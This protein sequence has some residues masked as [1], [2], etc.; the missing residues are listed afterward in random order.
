M[1]EG[2]NFAAGEVGFFVMHEMTGVWHRRHFGIAEILAQSIYPIALEDG[3]ALAP[4]DA[5]RQIDR[6]A[7]RLGRLAAHC[8][9]P[10]LVGADVPVEAA[11]E[12][13]R[14]EEVVDPG[15]DILVEG[16][17]IMRPMREEMAEIEAAGLARAADER[18]GPGLLVERLVPDLDEMLGR[19]PACADAGIWTVEEEQAA[20]TFAMLPREA[21]CNVRPDIMRDDAG[22]GDAERVH[23]RQNICGMDIRRRLCRKLQR[24]LLAVAEAAQVW[25]DHVEVARQIGNAFAPDQP[26]FRPA[27]Q[28][29]QRRTS[30]FAHIVDADA[31]R[32]HEARCE[33]RHGSEP[34]SPTIA[35]IAGAAKR[36]PSGIAPKP[37]GDCR[38]GLGGLAMTALRRLQRLI[39][40][41]DEVGGFLEAD[42]QPHQ[43]IIDAK[44][45]PLF[46]PQP[47]MRGGGGMRDKALAVAQVVR[48]LD[49]L[50]RVLEA[51]GTGLAAGHRN[52][53]QR[54]R[55]AHLPPSEL[56][57]RM[58]LQARIEHAH[59]LAVTLDESGDFGRR[60]A[61]P[62][63]P[64]IK[65]LDALEQKPGIER[66]E[67]RPGMAQERHQ[68]LAHEGV[69][70]EHGAA[71]AAP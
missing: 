30:P 39:E 6:R 67:R 15:L 5:R 9:E 44:R 54:A 53:H 26:E 48:D 35:V 24:R 40:I 19:R 16:M 66:A 63:D 13:A 3:I 17:G 71:E 60:A 42:G 25:R 32:L 12:I 18:G 46:R 62:V 56:V 14:L 4:K 8:R 36:S 55:P 7:L 65:G 33:L 43:P 2:P 58:A 37:E 61:L 51:E 59:D 69:G 64:Q 38:I 23:E 27:V 22:F 20:Q 68:A 1:K 57:L 34:L 49:Q 47:M 45:L 21:L 70:A 11:L 41:R 28:Q 29:E 10:S 50:E 52:G 31:V